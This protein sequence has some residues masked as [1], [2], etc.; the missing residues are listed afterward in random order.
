MTSLMTD[1]FAQRGLQVQLSLLEALGKEEL[2]GDDLLV[3]LVVLR[4]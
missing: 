1:G 4:L 2:E 3:E